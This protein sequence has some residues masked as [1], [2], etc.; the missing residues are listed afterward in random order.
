MPTVRLDIEY[1]GSDFQ[2]WA[3]Q[4]GARTVQGEL[5]AA[6]RTVLR[7]EV[8][9]TVAGRTD[10]GVHA[11]AQVASFEVE[12]EPPDGLLRSLNGV[13]SRQISVIAATIAEPG[14]NARR[15][16]RS[17]TYCYR[18]HRRGVASPFEAKRALWWPQR[19]DLDALASCAELV[20]GRHDFTAFTPTQTEH[21]HFTREVLRCEWLEEEE[22][23]I[24]S[25]WIEADS[26]MRSMVRVLTGTMLEVASG[27]RTVGSF[28]ALLG[29]SP[30]CEAGETAPAHGLYLAAVRY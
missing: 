26:F 16:A 11:W 4:P 19:L 12:A 17:R 25:L 3:A 29:G 10:A 7:E 9:L 8:S 6:L 15:D 13:I 21:V 1:V 5:E 20:H 18:L 22:G 30:R 27:G 23:D 2:G 14:F 28:I 24:V